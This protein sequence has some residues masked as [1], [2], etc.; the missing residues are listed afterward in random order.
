[1]STTK[2]PNPDT[3]SEKASAST[4]AKPLPDVELPHARPTKGGDPLTHP[5]GYSKFAPEPVPAI[6]EVKPAAP[7]KKDA[8]TRAVRPPPP[9]P[10]TRWRRP[11]APPEGDPQ[12]RKPPPGSASVLAAGEARY[13]PVP[14]MTVP[15]PRPAP[16]PPTPPMP[17]VPE[18]PA[19]NR[20]VNGPS[21]GGTPPSGM[22]NAFTS[23]G[24]SKP[25]PSANMPSDLAIN[26]FS[27][28]PTP[29]N[30]P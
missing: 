9:P 26:A 12:A 5:E 7:A 10:L 15:T 28:P 19:L 8:G 14:I 22:T 4:P 16:V 17:Q 18:A 23:P 13:V 1:T 6:P 3:T 11:A 25:I 30:A 2:S 21:A 24:P 20:M 27:G 29:H